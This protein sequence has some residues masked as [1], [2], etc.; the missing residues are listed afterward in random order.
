LAGLTTTS[1]QKLLQLVRGEIVSYDKYTTGELKVI[2]YPGFTN[3]DCVVKDKL[4]YAD[5]LSTYSHYS[6]IKVEGLTVDKFTDVHLFVNTRTSYS[7]KWHTDSVNVYLYVI[8][9][10]KRLQVKNKTYLLTAGQGAYIPKG[11]LHRAFSK[12]DTWALSIGY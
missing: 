10:Q 9:G 2:G 7:F 11:H 6:T 8:K 12:K 4:S 1:N 5:W 3:T